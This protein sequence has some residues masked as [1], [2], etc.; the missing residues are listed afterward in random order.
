MAFGS[1]IAQLELSLEEL[2]SEASSGDDDP[3]ALDH[4]DASASIT[5]ETSLPEKRKRRAL[6]D[7]L[8]REEV[9]HEPQGDCTQCG[10]TLKVSVPSRL[11]CGR[12]RKT[13]F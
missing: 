9:R 8:P 3:I 7:H 6:P 4:P 2:E 11:P 10:G 12:E 13:G 1:E 5:G